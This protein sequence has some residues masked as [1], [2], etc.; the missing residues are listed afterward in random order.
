MRAAETQPPLRQKLLA[1]RNGMMCRVNLDVALRSQRNASRWR[2]LNDVKESK[3][4][5][6]MV[7]KH[8]KVGPVSAPSQ[9]LVLARLSAWP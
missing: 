3:L 4:A 1:V 2:S 5:V 6:L 8:V 9:K 7:A